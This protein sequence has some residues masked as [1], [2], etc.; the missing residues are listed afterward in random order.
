M[1]TALEILNDWEKE[2]E[3]GGQECLIMAMNRYAEQ[4]IPEVFTKEPVNFLLVHALK[5]TPEQM[6]ELRDALSERIPKENILPL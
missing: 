2:I 6:I 3:Q 5:L 1:K 4:F